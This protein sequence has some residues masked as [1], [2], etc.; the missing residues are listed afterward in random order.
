MPAY[1]P[2]AKGT[3]LVPSGSD[4]WLGVQYWTVRGDQEICI[5]FKASRS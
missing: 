2:R 4:Q 1:L 5:G 3:D